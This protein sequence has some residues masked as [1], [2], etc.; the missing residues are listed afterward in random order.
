[1]I[2]DA[3]LAATR[4]SQ[5]GGAQIALVNAT[6]VRV[7]LPAGDVPYK[8]AFA[9]MPFGNNL[10]VMTLTGAA[11]RCR[12][13]AAVRDSAEVRPHPP[14]RARPVRRL[15]LRGR[16]VEAREQPR[17]RPAPQWQAIRTDRPLPRC[18]ERL[19]RVEAAT[20]SASSRRAPDITDGGIIDLDALVAWIAPSRT[21]PKL[22]R[23]RFDD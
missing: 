7:A 6:G 9:M 18:R 16:H 11:A 15:H 4:S 17:F 19:S 8:D 20:G 5:T 23:I 14:C 2:A 3:T 10:L 22:D 21:P 1:M 12:A 13:G